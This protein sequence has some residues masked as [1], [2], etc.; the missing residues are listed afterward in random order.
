MTFPD[1]DEF[2]PGPRE[3]RFVKAEPRPGQ[4]EV[5]S[6][7]QEWIEQLLSPEVLTLLRVGG[8]RIDVRLSSANGK[9]RPRPVVTFNGGPQ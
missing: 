3:F 8:D 4:L 7:V 6:F 1:V 9:A 2:P 5:P